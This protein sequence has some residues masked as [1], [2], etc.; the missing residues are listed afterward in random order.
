ME[1][2]DMKI[3]ILSMAAC[4]SA[5][6]ACGRVEDSA[7]I[8]NVER[9]DCNPIEIAFTGRLIGVA[10]IGGESTGY[11]LKATNAT[12]IELDLATNHLQAE[13]IVDRS[14]LVYGHFKTVVGI[15]IPTRQ[16]F[17]VV[18]IKQ[19]PSPT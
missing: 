2:S 5:L 14:V 3:I 8:K 6:I 1:N 13:F 11:G 18:S 10:A 7:S 12:V 4:F 16:V 9:R 15:E 17:E 19:L